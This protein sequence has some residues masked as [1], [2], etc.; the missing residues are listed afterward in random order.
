MICIALVKVAQDLHTVLVGA[1]GVIDVVVE[2]HTLEGVEMRTH[3]LEEVVGTALV[4]EAKENH[5][6]PVV[7]VYTL[8]GLMVCV[9]PVKVVS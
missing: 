9:A 1:E 4:R 5:T 2:V 7:A 6:D 8:L 3:T